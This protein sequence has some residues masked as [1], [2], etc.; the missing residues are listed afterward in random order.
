MGGA[1]DAGML[2]QRPMWALP[3]PKAPPPPSR[4]P[5][6]GRGLSGL[7][8]MPP[9]GGSPFP[10]RG[11]CGLAGLR[12]SG[13]SPNLAADHVAKKLA[14]MTSSAHSGSGHSGRAYELAMR[15]ASGLGLSGA[16]DRWASSPLSREVTAHGGESFDT[17]IEGPE[18]IRMRVE[19]DAAEA[20]R[21]GGVRDASPL[22][23]HTP[24]P[25]HTA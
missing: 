12:A 24:E 18:V 4:T 11:G 7:P 16:S 8:G 17:L 5:G 13:S 1:E 25:S 20:P 19:G 15:A 22:V 23:K 10:Q 6:A 14:V 3:D 21:G 9:P 2:V